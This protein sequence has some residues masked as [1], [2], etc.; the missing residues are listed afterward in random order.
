MFADPIAKGAETFKQR[1]KIRTSQPPA[2]LNASAVTM[3]F[4]AGTK[5]RDEHP[6][7]AQ[8]WVRYHDKYTKG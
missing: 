8:D 6:D 2:L 3:R 7:H 1:A 4:T 5:E